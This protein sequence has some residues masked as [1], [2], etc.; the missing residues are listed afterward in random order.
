M[1]IMPA[2]DDTQKLDNVTKNNQLGDSQGRKQPKPGFRLPAKTMD[3]ERIH[4]SLLSMNLHKRLTASSQLDLWVIEH[5]NRALPIGLYA[6]S[7]PT[8]NGQPAGP[9]RRL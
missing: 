7:R 2:T 5:L 6:R 3:L 4:I 8:L 9:F 1:E